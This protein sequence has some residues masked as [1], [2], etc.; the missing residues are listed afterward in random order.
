MGPVQPAS[1]TSAGFLGVGSVPTMHVLHKNFS[2]P[3]SEELDD[4]L[5]PVVAHDIPVDD[6]AHDIYM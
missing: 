3:A 1:L 2:Q 4:L 5:L 6:L